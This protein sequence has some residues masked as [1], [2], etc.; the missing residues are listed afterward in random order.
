MKIL[1][2][3][4]KTIHADERHRDFFTDQI[5]EEM[6]QYQSHI[7]RIEVH[8]TDQ[9]GK[10]EGM[11]DIRC[12]MEARLEGRQP[13]AVSDQADTVEAAVSGAIEHLQNALESILERKENYTV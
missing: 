13:I 12:L 5:A 9:N 1:I 2:N 3:T 6:D 8:I 10:K 4:D 7:T 11:N